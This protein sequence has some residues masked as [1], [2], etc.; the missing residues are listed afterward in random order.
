MNCFVQMLFLQLLDLLK[1][2]VC[3]LFFVD[4]LGERLFQIFKN[5]DIC[6]LNLVVIDGDFGVQLLRM[7]GARGP[8]EKQKHED[9]T[10]LHTH[11]GL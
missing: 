3:P 2:H 7:G 1:L 10:E 5:R 9:N 11:K 4:K 8:K 6:T